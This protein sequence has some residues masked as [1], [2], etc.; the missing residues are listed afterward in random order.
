MKTR[1]TPY[2]IQ[3]VQDACLKSY[4]RRKPLARFLN[5][6]GVD[7]GLLGSWGED[8]TKRDLLER[9]FESLPQ[10][11]DGRKRILIISRHLMEQRSFPDLLNWED[12]EKKVKEA[13][14]AVTRLRIHHKTQ[15]E[16]IRSE[17]EREA[18][19]KAFRERQA[20][21]AR[22]QQSL[23]KLKD[24]L[25][26]L[27]KEL[28]TQDAGYAFQDWFY[29]LADFSEIH[30]RRPYKTKGREI[31]GSLTIA[32]TTYLVELKFTNVQ[33]GANVIDSFYKKVIGKADNT[34]G[35]IVSVSGFSSVAIQ[36]ASGERTPLLLLDHGHLYQVLGGIMGLAE[37]IERVRRH[38]SQT[39][40]AFLD[41]NHFG[42]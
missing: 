1:I 2:Y 23:Q 28:G 25:D 39:G 18:A 24:R 31:D 34:M 27:G 17:I 38:A 15:D 33:A 37:V 35:V 41:A 21:V 11:D 13:H 14:D 36:E 12:S 16:V 22:S 20:D 32:S 30:N 9:L 4:W 29:D 5:Q 40:D 7:S 3:L 42:G 10:T 6:C 19:K 26:L 8:E